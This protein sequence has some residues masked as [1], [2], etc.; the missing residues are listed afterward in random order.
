MSRKSKIRGGSLQLVKATR[1][2]ESTRRKWDE[3]F[4]EENVG[5]C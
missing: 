1:V 5:S 3:N 2:H 4:A